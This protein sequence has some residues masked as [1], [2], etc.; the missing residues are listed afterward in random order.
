[1]KLFVA[2]SC[3]AASALPLAP[4]TAQPSSPE[5]N[6]T[7][8]KMAVSGEVLIALPVGDGFRSFAGPGLGLAAQFHY[9]LQ[10][11]LT[12]TARLG[13]VFHLKKDSDAR[14]SQLLLLGGA[15]YAPLG[16][17]EPLFVAAELGVNRFTVSNDVADVSN[18][19]LALHLSAG[20]TRGR[21]SFAGGL[22]VATLDEIGDSIVLLASAGYQ[23]VEF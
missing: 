22:L 1:M 10:P 5:G 12:L 9:R 16:P 21:L 4:A 14:L 15:R 23:F 18:S 3:L 20:Y 2:L 8:K 6:S 11:A 13:Y 19:E 7:A 17:N